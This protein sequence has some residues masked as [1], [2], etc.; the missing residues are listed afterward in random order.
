MATINEIKASASEHFA[1][2]QAALLNEFASVRTGRA[3][4]GLFDK[5]TVEAYGSQMPLNQVASVKTP[6]A[7]TVVIEPWD[8]GTISAIERAIQSSDLGLSPNNDGRLIRVPFPPLTEE[9]RREL[10]KLC[11]NYAEEARVAIRNIRR[12]A[13]QKLDRMKTDKEAGEDELYHAEQDVQK[14]TDKAIEE[15]AAALDK[16]EK[17]IMEV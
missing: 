5:I 3:A 11:K 2:T 17:E 13:N 14:L 6:D 7:Q 1:K 9:R 10:A 16:K 12:D 15:I 8:K 4:V